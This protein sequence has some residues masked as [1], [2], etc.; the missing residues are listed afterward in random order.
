V[1]ELFTQLQNRVLRFDG[2]SV[3]SPEMVAQCLLLGSEPAKLRVT[4]DCWE[5]SQFNQNA[6]DEEQIKV[7]TC[8]PISLNFSWHLP[9][10]YRELDLREYLLDT[11]APII[12]E[13]YSEIDQ[14]IAIQ[15]VVDELDEIYR[16]GLV[17]FVKT[18]IFVIDT[19]KKDGVVWGVGRGSSCA[20][21]ILFI[22]GLHSVDCIRLDIPM[23]EFFHD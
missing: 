8:D 9:Q 15:R 16:R 14:P 18:V 3:V 12:S 10:E 7:G 4:E 23:S 2:V 11:A 6:P 5:V 22:L 13:R 17:E 21:F 1:K 20:S 19:F